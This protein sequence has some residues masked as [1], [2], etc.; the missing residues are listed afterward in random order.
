MTLVEHSDSLDILP[1]DLTAS[2]ARD[3]TSKIARTGDQLANLVRSAW[4][5][6]VWLALGYESWADWA[7]AAIREHQHEGNHFMK[8]RPDAYSTS[9]EHGDMFQVEVLSGEGRYW[10]DMSEHSTRRAAE[11]AVEHFRTPRTAQQRLMGFA[12]HSRSSFRIR[13]FVLAEV[14]EVEQ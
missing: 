3:I 7:A 8:A 13:R 4:R 12:D 14:I 6:R 5:G 10:V 9:F 1:T 2:E 11:L